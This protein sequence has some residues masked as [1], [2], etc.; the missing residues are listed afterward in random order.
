MASATDGRKRAAGPALAVLVAVLAIPVIV[1]APLVL[2]L[3]EHLLFGTDYV[4]GFFRWVGLH[5]ALDAIYT[6]VIDFFRNL[7]LGP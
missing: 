7:G 3:A 2:A 4:E 6:P 5:D 1:F